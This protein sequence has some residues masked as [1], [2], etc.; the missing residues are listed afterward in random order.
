[1]CDIGDTVFRCN[2]DAFV[3]PRRINQD[4]VENWFSLMRGA[5]TNSNPTAMEITNNTQNC[6]ASKDIQRK[7]MVKGNTQSISFSA[8]PVSAVVSYPST[9]SQRLRLPDPPAEEAQGPDASTVEAVLAHMTKAPPTFDGR[10]KTWERIRRERRTFSLL[11]LDARILDLVARQRGI[12]ISLGT[13]VIELLRNRLMELQVGASSKLKKAAAHCALQKFAWNKLPASMWLEFTRKVSWTNCIEQRVARVL[14]FTL[15]TDTYVMWVEGYMGGDLQEFKPAKEPQLT[16][17]E[18]LQ[19]TKVF[20]MAGWAVRKL[21]CNLKLLTAAKSRVKAEVLGWMAGNFYEKG[22]GATKTCLITQGDLTPLKCTMGTTRSY[23][24]AAYTRDNERFGGLTFVK[25]DVFMFFLKLELMYHRCVSDDFLLEYAAALPVHACDYLQKNAEAGFNEIWGPLLMQEGA[26][27]TITTAHGKEMFLRIIQKYFRSRFGEFMKTV[28]IKLK[29][30]PKTASLRGILKATETGGKKRGRGSDQ[31]LNKGK[32]LKAFLARSALEV[33]YDLLARCGREDSEWEPN[34]QAFKVTQLR[35]LLLAYTPPSESNPSFRNKDDL[36]EAVHKRLVACFEECHAPYN[37]GAL[38]GVVNPPPSH[39]ST[40][41]AN[42][43]NAPANV[44]AGSNAPAPT[45]SNVPAGN[46]AGRTAPPTPT[47]NVPT[48]PAPVPAHESTAARSNPA[49]AGHVSLP[50]ASPLPWREPTAAPSAQPRMLVENETY[51]AEVNTVAALPPAFDKLLRDAV[52][53][54]WG[55]MG[56]VGGGRCGP[57]GVM[58]ALDLHVRCPGGETQRFRDHPEERLVDVQR[59]QWAVELERNPVHRQWYT[60]NEFFV[61][62]SFE[63]F[64]LR[65][66]TCNRSFDFYDLSWLGFRY[67]VNIGT[68]TGNI[69]NTG[70]AAGVVTLTATWR[71]CNFPGRQLG[72]P[73]VILYLKAIGGSGHFE[74]CVHS[75]LS[76]LGPWSGLIADSEDLFQALDTPSFDDQ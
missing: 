65:V 49:N 43:S 22:E 40:G 28:N 6:L 54:P 38:S 74:L 36:V 42:I 7:I 53:C 34:L 62:G 18:P 50:P 4:S 19:L 20:Y 64:I 9:R 72:K 70:R 55:R 63:D 51:M 47:V 27:H 3:Q 44:P 8:S 76:D 12:F 25:K 16:V 30:A 57:G 13:K 41:P 48:A 5:T 56:T 71:D 61:L 46:S 52:G 75:C 69:S 35:Q 15:V 17:L 31:P 11:A 39:S 37:M 21:L 66:R 58:W 14:C 24:V 26:P 59:E 32:V 60:D 10:K 2:R 67:G 33:H 1:M 23:D 45:N 68:L 73:W 29:L